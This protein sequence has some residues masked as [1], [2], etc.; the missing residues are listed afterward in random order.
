[1]KAMIERLM[2]NEALVI[3]MSQLRTSSPFAISSQQPF[4][5][6]GLPEVEDL[7]LRLI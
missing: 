3:E 7:P 5:Q 6:E 2:K 1:M 4:M